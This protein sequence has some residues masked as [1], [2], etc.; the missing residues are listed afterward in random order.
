MA[1]VREVQQEIAD[2]E[3]TIAEKILYGTLPNGQRVGVG[4]AVS[5]EAEIAAD[6][7]AGGSVM[8]LNYE[9][10]KRGVRVLDGKPWGYGPARKEGPNA[11]ERWWQSIGPKGRKCIVA[12][13]TKVN[14]L[15]E[16]DR[17]TFFATVGPDSE[18]NE[19]PS[20]DAPSEDK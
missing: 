8:A 18:Q 10:A 17:E 20:T 13:Y 11:F 3:E 7:A 14:G 4:D 6:R 1:T 2:P 16:E 19:P 9:L 5:A 15:P 12:L